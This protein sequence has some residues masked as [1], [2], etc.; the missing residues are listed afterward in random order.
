MEKTI[1]QQQLEL[2][3]ELM[4]KINEEEVSYSPYGTSNEESFLSGI[5]EGLSRARDVLQTRYYAIE[6]QHG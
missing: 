1:R 4:E 5:N 3:T 6:D 2:L